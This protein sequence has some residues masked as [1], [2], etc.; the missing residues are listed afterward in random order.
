[1]VKMQLTAGAACI[2]ARSHRYVQAIHFH[3]RLHNCVEMITQAG[4]PI[5]WG[6]EGLGGGGYNET[7]N[8]KIDVYAIYV[9]A[10]VYMVAILPRLL[11]SHL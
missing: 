3:N 9:I 8:S 5:L 6:G 10:T 2:Y 1:M 7:A 4:N 11:H